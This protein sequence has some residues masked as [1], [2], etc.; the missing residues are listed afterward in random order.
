MH[1]LAPI[2]LF[3]YNRPEHTRQTLLALSENLL[4]EQSRLFI[5]CDGPKPNADEKQLKKIQEVR[6]IIKSK[7][8]CGTV[9]V[10]EQKTNKGLANSVIDGVTNI[11][12]QFGKVIVLEDDLVTS[13]YFLE[14]MNTALEKY[15]DEE[16]VMQVSGH[17][18]PVKQWE[19]SNQAFFLPFTTSW[20]WGTWKRAWECFDINARRFKILDLSPE[21]RS[22]FDLKDSVRYSEMLKIQMTTSEIDS[23]AIRW[24]F[25]VFLQKGI[26]LFPDRS[27]VRN[28]GFGTE[29]THTTQNV[30]GDSDFNGDYRIT[31]L[32]TSFDI[33]QDAFDSVCRYL[34][35]KSG[36]LKS[37]VQAK[38]SFFQRILSVIS[39]SKH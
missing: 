18:F 27:L 23:W 30:Y 24:W 4:A 17:Q 15:K 5:F 26:V 19:K 7:K 38:K 2:V 39:K 29:A 37:T 36:V 3:C 10:V 20:G 28:I 1:E 14:Y 6:E 13:N 8:W 31:N 34:K 22:E 12:N 11:V 9:D 16:K 33:N 21:M 25:S 32:P 35:T